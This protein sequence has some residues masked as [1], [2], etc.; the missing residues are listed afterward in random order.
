MAVVSDRVRATL[1]NR[2]RGNYTA[3]VRV[4]S[5]PQVAARLWSTGASSGGTGVAG[6]QS[7]LARGGNLSPPSRRMVSATAIGGGAGRSA[8]DVSEEGAL[9]RKKAC[10]SGRK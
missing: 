3:G 5:M 2:L 10:W 4:G 1:T 9:G 8:V 6:G 7:S